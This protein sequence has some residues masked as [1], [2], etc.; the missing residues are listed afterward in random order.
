MGV[1]A[2]AGV[3]GAGVGEDRSG[4]GVAVGVTTGVEVGAGLA[5]AVGDCVTGDSVGKGAGVSSPPHDRAAMR[6]RMVS[7]APA[8]GGR[9]LLRLPRR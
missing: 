4:E 2:G 3:A 1:E 9:G 6:V 7:T 8:Q 5:T